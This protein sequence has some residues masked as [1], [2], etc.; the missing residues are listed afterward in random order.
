TAVA[1][2][3]CFK[4]CSCDF[5]RYDAGLERLYSCLVGVRI[6]DCVVWR[7]SCCRHNLSKTILV[8]INTYRV[9]KMELRQIRYFQRVAAELNFT[10]A[11]KAL[12][13]AQPPLSRQIRM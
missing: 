9:W 1:G 7:L 10:R 5:A 4:M 6:L 3:V 13:I 11:A 12:H 2:R 8:R